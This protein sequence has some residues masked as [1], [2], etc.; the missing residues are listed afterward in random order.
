MLASLGL[1]AFVG[2]SIRSSS[3]AAGRADHLVANNAGPDPYALMQGLCFTNEGEQQGTALCPHS[4]HDCRGVAMTMPLASAQKVTARHLQRQAMLYTLSR[5]S[6]GYMLTPCVI[7][8]RH[9]I[10]QRNWR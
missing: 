3:T 8:V 4:S 5:V 7:F 6:I 9:E 2:S 10:T 1:A